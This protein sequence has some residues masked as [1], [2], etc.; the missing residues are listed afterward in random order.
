MSKPFES[1]DPLL[2]ISVATLAKKVVEYL[3]Y[4]EVTQGTDTE[5]IKKLETDIQLVKDHIKKCRG[6]AR[7]YEAMNW[8]SQPPVE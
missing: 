8:I 3:M 5:S 4:L 7:V 2:Q 1:I 6:A